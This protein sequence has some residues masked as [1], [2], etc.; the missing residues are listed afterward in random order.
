MQ[1]AK[2][3]FLEYFEQKEKEANI[4]NDGGGNDADNRK[5]PAEGDLQVVSEKRLSSAESPVSEQ[6]KHEDDERRCNTHRLTDFCYLLTA[7]ATNVLTNKL[8]ASTLPP[9]RHFDLPDQLMFP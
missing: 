7:C 5:L 8:S 3:S 4:Q 2:P 6:S 1:P 9:R